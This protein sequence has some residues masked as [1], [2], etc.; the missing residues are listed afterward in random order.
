MSRFTWCARLGLPSIVGLAL[1]GAETSAQDQPTFR[2]SVDVVTI[3]AYAHRDRKPIPGLTARDFVVR[4][5]GV[6]QPVDSLGTTDS[7]HVII[8]LD[9]SGSVDG[10]TLEQ[11]KSAVRTLAGQLTPADRVSLFTFSDRLRLLLR[12]ATPG[13][14]LES[15][16]ARFAAGG[17]T[18]LQDAMV[19][20][21]ALSLADTRPSV[22]LLFTDGQDTTSWTSAARALDVL[23]RTNV[24][25]F[26]VGAGLPVT[27]TSAPFADALTRQPWMAATP[28]DGLRLL[29][30]AADLTGGEFLRVEKDAKLSE[31]FQGILGQY[32]QRY[33]LTYT[34]AT[35]APGFHKLEVRLRG[36]PGEVVAREGY[37]AR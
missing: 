10:R 16:L 13:G 2:A 15:A 32:R 21:A 30:S 6:E 24:V 25:V 14:D 36:R 26:P 29:Q 9:L 12:A 5:N 27:I 19:L 28:G 31:T 23:R 3:D 1:L 8:G 20:G 33:L 35:T 37:V 18:P 11:L 7:A 22:F 17:A 4:D 34:P